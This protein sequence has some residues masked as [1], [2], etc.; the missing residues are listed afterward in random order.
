MSLILSAIGMNIKNGIFDFL[1]FSSKLV[2]FLIAAVDY[3]AFFI[4]NFGFLQQYSV[5]L[6]FAYFA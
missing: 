4:S 6:I 2:R 1:M 3:A 5:K